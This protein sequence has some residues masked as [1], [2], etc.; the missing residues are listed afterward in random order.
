LRA[1]VC[2]SDPWARRAL[3]VLAEKAG[4][5]IVGEATNAIEAVRL[6][7]L[8]QPTLVILSNEHFGLSGLEVTPDLRRVDDPPEV[9]LVSLDGSAR[10]K[11]KEMGAFEL[12]VKGDAEMIERM[13]SELREL[14][15]TGERRKSRDRRSGVDRR[16]RQDWSQVTYERRTGVERRGTI[17]REQDVTAAAKA[18]LLQRQRP[19]TP[20]AQPHPTSAAS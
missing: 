1:I 18:I 2:D 13:L 5:E 15:E 4:F 19:S 7:E 8:L 9:L 16:Q 12:A 14:L 6:T 17:R 10:A 3:E 11:A 20:P